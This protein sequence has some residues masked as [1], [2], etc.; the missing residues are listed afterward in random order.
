MDLGGCS[1]GDYKIKCEFAWSIVVHGFVKRERARRARQAAGALVDEGLP[2]LLPCAR[3]RQPWLT[4]TPLNRRPTCKH[5][6]IPKGRRIFVPSPIRCIT[7]N[8]VESDNNVIFNNF[9]WYVHKSVEIK[10]YLN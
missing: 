6:A 3:A 10:Y 7:L 2:R 1:G 9:I 8:L 5:R 4:C